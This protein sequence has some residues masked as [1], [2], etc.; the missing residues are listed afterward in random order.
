MANVMAI[1]SFR[2]G[3][4][5]DL[6]TTGPSVQRHGVLHSSAFDTHR[7]AV[8]FADFASCMYLETSS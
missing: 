5:S 2:F 7:G 3:P 4:P 8:A 6:P 1:I